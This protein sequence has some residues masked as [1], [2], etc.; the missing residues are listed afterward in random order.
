MGSVP[1]SAPPREGARRRTLLV[2]LL[3]LFVALLA[4]RTVDA[5]HLP[6]VAGAPPARTVWHS[7]NITLATPPGEQPRYVCLLVQRAPRASEPWLSVGWTDVVRSL[8]HDRARSPTQALATG[9][10]RWMPEEP[11]AGDRTR[12]RREPAAEDRCC[13]GTDDRCAASRDCCPGLEGQ[14][15]TWH[16]FDAL[17]RTPFLPLAASCQAQVATRAEESSSSSA[18]PPQPGASDHNFVASCVENERYVPGRVR[19]R[20]LLLE[21]YGPV[22]R[23]P[24][25]TFL[26][27]VGDLLVLR[28]QAPATRLNDLG[29]H[30]VAGHYLIGG[31]LPLT[32]QQ[33]TLSLQPTCVVRE[34]SLP[35]AALRDGAIATAT[36]ESGGAQA[37]PEPLAPPFLVALPTMR[38]SELSEQRL[39]VSFQRHG[40]TVGALRAR[41]RQ[42]IPP[43]ELPFRVNQ[44]VFSWANPNEY[45]SDALCPKATLEAFALDCEPVGPA[46]PGGRRCEYTCD[47]ASVAN[48]DV[49]LPLRVRF[50]SPTTS[51]HWFDS[52]ESFEQ[53]LNA[54]PDPQTRHLVA[55]L[56]DWPS[57]LRNSDEI[58]EYNVITESD[59]TFHLYPPRPSDP[60]LPVP[61]TTLVTVPGA[62]HGTTLRILPF[63]MHPFRREFTNVRGGRFSVPN[64]AD[65]IQRVRFG[66]RLGGQAA[67]LLYP[68]AEI[69]WKVGVHAEATLRIIF[70]S[71]RYNTRFV[72]FDVSLHYEL[73]ELPYQPLYFDVPAVGAGTDS[74]WYNRLGISL[75][76]LLPLPNGFYL[77]LIG[78]WMAGWPLR[79]QVSSVGSLFHFW[80]F[81]VTGHVAVTRHLAF[82]LDVLGQ[83]LPI[84]RFDAEGFRGDPALITDDWRPGLGIRLGFRYW[85]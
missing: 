70:P 57:D 65:L 2:A 34:L 66:A 23:R 10:L 36:F 54:A 16:A 5:Q 35:S 39:T 73:A 13:D 80:S 31:S 43:D 20:V 83:I 1:V 63:G 52:I 71:L 49:P 48:D 37:P 72:P 50:E 8:L 76:L 38:A 7:H 40:R 21:A 3:G 28:Y 9:L 11:S 56:Q 15:R 45:P 64:P 58:E 75:S 22:A 68:G 33:E 60:N 14:C 69:P 81:G 42:A 18:Q 26:T 44:L 55:E 24:G 67:G 74:I 46:V 17:F 12:R 25:S 77:G 85:I 62:R 82:E 47:V 53:V 59:Q 51:D 30:P 84:P 27:L 19:D 61:T 4:T 32:H 6:S 29:L 79:E 78:G 41:W